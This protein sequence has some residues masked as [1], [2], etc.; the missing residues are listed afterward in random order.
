M[1]LYQIFWL[2]IV[3]DILLRGRYSPMHR[4]KLVGQESELSKSGWRYAVANDCVSSSPQSMQVT[5]P[6]VYHT[7]AKLPKVV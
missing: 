4:I 2:A 1:G 5:I 7:T 6:T 3:N